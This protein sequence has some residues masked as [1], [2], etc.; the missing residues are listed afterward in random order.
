MTARDHTSYREEIG[1]YLLGALTDPERHSFEQHIATCAEC[2]AEVE[3]L[4]PA[5]D[6]LPRSVEQME[7]PAGLKASLMKAVEGEAR[8]RSVAPPRRSPW[9]RLLPR[10]GL[11]RPALAAGAALAVG[12]LAGIGIAQLGAGDERTV[13]ARVTGGQAQGA[14]A[15]LQVDDGR[16]TLTA[17]GLREPPGG[18][19]Y[20]VWVLRRGEQAPRPDAVFLPDDSGRADVPVQGSLK[21]GDQVLVTPERDAQVTAPEGRPFI[22]VSVPA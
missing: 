8:E 16:G 22:S 13:A 12:L 1:A 7:P 11:F 6:V 18:G 21:D 17:S 10:G 14:R 2:R 15:E 20:K 3:R 4:R 5:A 19:V 9:E